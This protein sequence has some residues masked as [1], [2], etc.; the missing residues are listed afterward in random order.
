MRIRLVAVGRRMP[1][2][3]DEGVREYTRRL[4]QGC[5]LEVVAVDAVTRHKNTD[6][7]RA[8]AEEGRRLLRAAG[9]AHRVALDGRGSP[10]ST[11]DLAARLERWSHHGGEVALLVGG[12]DGLDPHT[13]AQCPERWSLGPLTLPH[14]LVRII[15]AEQIY[16]A[17]SLNQGHPYHRA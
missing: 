5:T 16:R 11:E 6:P 9:A 14:P 2:W 8:M 13:L 17:W 10:W 1:P 12:A 3:V 7:A 15:V 4:R